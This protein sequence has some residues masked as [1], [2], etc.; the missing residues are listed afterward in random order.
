MHR[1]RHRH[2]TCA[3][4]VF[5]LAVTDPTLIKSVS[6]AQRNKVRTTCN[7]SLRTMATIATAGKPQQSP[8]ILSNKT[9]FSLGNTRYL[10]TGPA[11]GKRWHARALKPNPGS[12]RNQQKITQEF[13]ESVILKCLD[14]E[15]GACA[16]TFRTKTGANL[17]PIMQTGGAPRE[18]LF[19]QGGG[20]F[21][22]A[23]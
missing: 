16:Q 21:V 13:D 14:T 7:S 4:V 2:D 22:S 18:P 5:Y 6:D 3:V 10:V 23:R 15:Q 17:P 1:R 11:K 20:C 19:R 8:K 9:E 12:V